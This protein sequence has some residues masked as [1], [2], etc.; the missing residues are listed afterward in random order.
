MRERSETPPPVLAEQPELPII[1]S[2]NDWLEQRYSANGRISRMGD[3]P[4]VSPMSDT[5]AGLPTD[6][7][8]REARLRVIACCL[9]RLCRNTSKRARP[10]RFWD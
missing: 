9:R 1:N 3:I 10:N 5:G 8:V 6:A 7:F 2:V 4:E